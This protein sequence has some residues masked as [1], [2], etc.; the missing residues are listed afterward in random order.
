MPFSI[1]VVVS[2]HQIPLTPNTPLL[3]RI[4]S[5]MRSEVQPML[6]TLHRR[7]LPN[8]VNAPTVIISTHKNASLNPTMIK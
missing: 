3:K 6:I 1:V 4:A 8:P 2:A 5:G 7:V